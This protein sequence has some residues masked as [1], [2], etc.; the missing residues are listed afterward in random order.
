MRPLVFYVFAS[1]DALWMSHCLRRHGGD[2]AFHHN[3]KTTTFF[4]RTR[5]QGLPC[6]PPLAVRGFG[7]DFLYRRWY[8][9]HMSLKDYVPPVDDPMAKSIRKMDVNQISYQE[10]YEYVAWA[11]LLVVMMWCSRP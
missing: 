7:S 9:S 1:E 6:N 4:P 8:R 10:Y 11:R 3:W 5:P 2:F